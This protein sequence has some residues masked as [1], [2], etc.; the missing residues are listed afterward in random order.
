MYLTSGVWEAFYRT[1][2]RA[3]KLFVRL[4]TEIA[5][6]RLPFLADCSK[7]ADSVLED[8]DRIPLIC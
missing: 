8:L 3:P 1:I 4:P 2:G 6:I 5:V 7:E